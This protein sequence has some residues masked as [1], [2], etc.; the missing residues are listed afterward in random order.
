MLTR[1]YV[2][3]GYVK[4][5]Y[6]AKPSVVSLPFD[7]SLTIIS[8]YANSPT[9]RQL[10]DCM[11][12]Y[13]DPS[14]DFENFYDAVWNIDSAAGFGLDIWGKIVGV[15]RQ[16]EIPA[17][18]QFFGFNEGSDYQPFGQAPFYNGPKA[19]NT[20]SL[21]DDAYRTLILMKALLNI[22]NCS[23]PAINRLLSNLFAGRG[24][25]YVVDN[26]NMSINFVF[27]FSL[28]PYEVAILTKS[29]AIPKPAGVSVT[30][31]YPNQGS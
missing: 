1:D 14:T 26:G 10:L 11:A 31:V 20:Y 27:E 25:C 21:S 9:L 28:N 29:S 22:S 4:D 6:I 12:Q 30:L 15:A 23:A 19:T 17:T 13:F 3:S 7:A 2:L 16:L 8:Q 24:K 18:Q 5:G